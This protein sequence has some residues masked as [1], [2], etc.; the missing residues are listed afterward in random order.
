VEESVLRAETTLRL[1]LHSTLTTTTTNKPEQTMPPIVCKKVLWNR[2]GPFNSIE[3][4]TNSYAM[5]IMGGM[6]WESYSE[7]KRSDRNK[8]DECKCRV[9]VF[10]GFPAKSH[11]AE[12]TTMRCLRAFCKKKK[13][14]T[15]AADTQHH[16]SS[17]DASN[18]G[19]LLETNKFGQF[20]KLFVNRS[21]DHLPPYCRH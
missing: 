13:M 11:F 3:S 7:K 8:G 16:C 10:G 21:D 14:G 17:A 4:S 19:C 15:R 2:G 1:L 12:T 20:A 9:T 18:K 5:M 6:R